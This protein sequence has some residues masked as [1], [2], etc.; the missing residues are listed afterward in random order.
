MRHAL[1]CS[2]MLVAAACARGLGMVCSFPQKKQTSEKVIKLQ[3][4]S[5]CP[6]VLLAQQL[7]P[8]SSVDLAKQL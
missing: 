2:I 7:V 3:S 4:E 5:I 8:K 1:P 6:V